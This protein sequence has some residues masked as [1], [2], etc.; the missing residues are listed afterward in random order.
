MIPELGHLAMILALCL[1]VGLGA[2]LLQFGSPCQTLL[3][4]GVLLGGRRC[5]PV[6]ADRMPRGRR[7][8]A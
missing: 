1:A 4:V 8:M 2:L 6:H 7:R 3:P 5:L